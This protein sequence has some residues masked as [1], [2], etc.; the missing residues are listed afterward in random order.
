MGRCVIFD[1]FFGETTSEMRY[2]IYLSN[3]YKHN[4]RALNTYDKS[5]ANDFLRTCT[6]QYIYLRI[7]D[8]KENVVSLECQLERWK[9]KEMDCKPNEVAPVSAWGD[10]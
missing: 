2:E 6:A 7:L 8:E 4:W 5:E 3:Y 9:F 10:K 1:G